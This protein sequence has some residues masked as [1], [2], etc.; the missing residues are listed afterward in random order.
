PPICPLPQTAL[1]SLSI[2]PSSALP[3]DALNSTVD[4]SFCESPPAPGPQPPS[5][6]L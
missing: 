4:T 3:G 2:S 6:S 5:P 1:V